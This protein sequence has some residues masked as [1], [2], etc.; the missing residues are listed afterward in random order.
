MSHA[1]SHTKPTAPVRR[2]AHRQPNQVAIHGTVSG[3]IIAP[4]LDP[5]LKIPVA[6]ARSF[7]GNHSAT[8][9]TA[10]GKFP[11]SPSPS[12][13]RATPNPKTDRAPA[14]AMAAR[15]Q[16]VTATEN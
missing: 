14:A 9:F 4:T 6:S 16:T 5:G 15:L 13:K 11:A 1:T 3:A 10:A 12:A 7:F 2:N 8:V